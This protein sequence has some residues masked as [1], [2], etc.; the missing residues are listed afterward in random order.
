MGFLRAVHRFF[1]VEYFGSL[2]QKQVEESRHWKYLV[3]EEI[4]RGGPALRAPPREKGPDPPP[5][6]RTEQDQKK[7]RSWIHLRR[8]RRNAHLSP[9]PKAKEPNK[10]A[11]KDE[12][13][14][15]QR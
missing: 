5:T 6:E 14:M 7:R 2:E 15:T 11:S 1:G 8:C 10:K 13:R 9:L 12:R 3:T 4:K